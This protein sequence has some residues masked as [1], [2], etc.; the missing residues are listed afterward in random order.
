MHSEI[1]NGVDVIGIELT[2][3]YAE[4]KNNNT[5]YKYVIIHDF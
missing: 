4:I 3:T 5:Q 1:F 2:N